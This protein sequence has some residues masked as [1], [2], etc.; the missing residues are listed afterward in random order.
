MYSRPAPF[1]LFLL[2]TLALVASA[3]GDAEVDD[4]DAVE[5]ADMPEAT[6]P[7]AVDDAT[8]APGG[9]LLDP[10]TATRDQLAALPGMTPELADELLGERPFETML[11]VDAVLEDELSESQREELYR[12]MFLPLDLNTASSDEI[13]LIPG[14][15]DRMTHEFEEYRP[16]SEMAQFRREMGK[17]VDEDEVARLERYVVI[18]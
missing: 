8:P 15:G 16:Y 13:M 12:H 17:Y 7:A 9:A 2:T 1:R 18:R 5:D 10:S 11:D 14:V 3:C 4:M 6:A